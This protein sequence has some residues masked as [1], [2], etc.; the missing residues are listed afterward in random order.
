MHQLVVLSTRWAEFFHSMLDGVHHSSIFFVVDHCILFYFIFVLGH[1]FL[2]PD[3][4]H[5]YSTHL[6]TFINI[7]PTLVPYELSPTDITTLI[8]N[9]PI[10]LVTIL[11]TYPINLITLLTTYPTNLTSLLT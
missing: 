1:F 8:I 7:V 10:D 2:G 4:T 3:L 11:I 5:N 6:P 9:Y